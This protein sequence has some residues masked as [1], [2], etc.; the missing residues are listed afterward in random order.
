MLGKT[1][2]GEGAIQD[3]MVGQHHQLNGHQFEQTPEYSERQGSWPC[4]SPWGRKELD[5][6]G[7]L[8]N[9]NIVLELIHLQIR[10]HGIEKSDCKV[11]C[12]FSI[13]Q[14]SAPLV[15]IMLMGKYVCYSSLKYVIDI[16]KHCIES[17][18]LFGQYGHFNNINS[19]NPWA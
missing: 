14:Q 2:G 12:T 11:I 17:V 13:V 7:Q 9:N 8:N 16:Y 18:D 15:P 6:N 5:T 1:K 3:E 4:C 10:N 19:F